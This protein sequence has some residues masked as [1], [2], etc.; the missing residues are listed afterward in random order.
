MDYYKM[1]CMLHSARGTVSSIGPFIQIGNTYVMGSVGFGVDAIR[2]NL[3]LSTEL[4]LKSY[5]ILTKGAHLFEH[6]LVNLTNDIDQNFVNCIEL[7]FIELWNLGN[8]L[9]ATYLAKML[10]SELDLRNEINY[11]YLPYSNLL[12][13]MYIHRR[14]FVDRRY[15]H[16]TVEPGPPSG[17]LQ[18][19]GYEKLWYVC[20]AIKDALIC[21]FETSDYKDEN[22]RI[23]DFVHEINIGGTKDLDGFDRAK[24]T[25]ELFRTYV[26]RESTPPQG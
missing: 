23:V 2:V 25:M 20:T 11:S 22:Y 7:K 3:S 9:S 1:S 6:D 18:R 15:S 8:L 17:A 19:S 14:F 24:D 5:A 26:D 12:K 13:E 10:D 16:A 21:V 4:F